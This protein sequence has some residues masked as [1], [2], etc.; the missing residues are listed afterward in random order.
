M[1]EVPFDDMVTDLIRAAQN[2][3]TETEWGGGTKS[4]E[5]YLGRTE[6]DLLDAIIALQQRAEKAEAKASGLDEMSE[7]YKGM[8]RAKDANLLALE[9]ENKRLEAENKRLREA[10]E[11]ITELG[12]Q[13][14]PVDKRWG[15]AFA[16]AREALKG[17]EE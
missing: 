3:A 14:L 4:A 10:L 15:T 11:N 17:G 13:H 16:F 1:S 2:V 8:L 12:L 5:E 9:S 6:H 7:M